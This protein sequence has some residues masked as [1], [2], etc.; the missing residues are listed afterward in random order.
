MSSSHGVS[1][2]EASLKGYQ[3]YCDNMKRAWLYLTKNGDTELAIES[4][5]AERT[6]EAGIM[7][8]ILR[9]QGFVWVDF[10]EE[11]LRPLRSLPEELGLFSDKGNLIFNGRYL[12]PVKDMVG[13]IVAI[14]GW[15]D[16][17]KKYITTPG[18]YYS[19][20][21]LLFGLE[22]MEE[23]RPEGSFVVEGIF[24][25]L[26]LR[27]LGFRAFA[28]MGVTAKLPQQALWSTIGRIVGIPDR[29]TQ[30]RKQRK[31]DNWALPVG[32]SYLHWSGSVLTEDGD[33]VPIKDIDDIC[34]VF[35]PETVIEI[36]T[37]CLSEKKRQIKIEI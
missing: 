20:S 30:G 10:N 23:K 32:S 25:S 6:Y 15:Y 37:E 17:F 26:C 24:D 35:P 16:D 19:K 36:L 3:E 28:L 8:P 1:G 34:K 29:D 5:L 31:R 27:A 12:F 18:K 2:T 11:T 7:E 22:Q 14:I 4:I 21:I 9:E 13:N 33:E